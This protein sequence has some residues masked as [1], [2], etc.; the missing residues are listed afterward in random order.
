VSEEVSVAG[1]VGADRG[2]VAAGRDVVARLLVT[3]DRNSFFSGG[4]QRLDEAYIDPWSVFERVRL[5]RFIGRE[6]LEREVDRFLAENERGY[7]ILE[8]KA[9]LGK[10]AFFAHLVRERGWIS[11]FVEL[12]P[13][14]AGVVPAR[15]NLA[16]QVI[17]GYELGEGGEEPVLPDETAS[18]PDFLQNLLRKAAEKRRDGEKIVL[19]VDGLDEAGARPG[20][21]VLGLPR[22]LPA[23]VFFLVSKRPVP[24]PLMVERPRRVVPL[25]A[26]S[27]ANLG[28]VRAY[29]ERATNWDGI[30]CALRERPTPEGS[31]DGAEELVEALLAKSGGVWVYLHYVLS[32]IEEAHRPEARNHPQVD[33]DALPEG[34]WAYYAD[35]WRRWKEEHGDQWPRVHRPLLATLAAA[36]EDV[37]LKHLCMLAGIDEV[38][39]L[40][41]RW[42]PFLAV[43]KGEEPAYRLYHGSLEDFLHGRV[44]P[45]ELAEDEEAFADEL[46]R[47]TREAH[48]RIAE[49]YLSAWGGLEIGL[50]GLG[51]EGAR[52]L[53]GRYG[54]RRVAF[55]LVRAGREDAL[56]RL[57]QLERQDGPAP[58]NIWFATREGIDEIAGY[59][60][61]VAMA[62]QAAEDASR[63]DLERG[64]Q[65]A[66]IGLE[67]RCALLT[68]SVGSLA[69]ALP[70]TLL[71]ALVEQGMWTVERAYGYTRQ[72]RD[73][74]HRALALGGLAPRLPQ[75]DR[76]K[77]FADALAATRAIGSE[78][79]PSDASSLAGWIAQTRGQALV[80]LAPHL[81]DDLIPEAVA[82]AQAIGEH[83]SGS[84]ALAALL[85]R[86]PDE[87]LAQALTTARAI[88]YEPPRAQ[89]LAELAPRLSDD[90]LTEA[91]AAARAIGYEKGRSRALA[92][93]ASRLPETG[94]D[95]VLA[96]AL[97]AARAAK[98]AEERSQA[99]AELIPLLPEV[100]RAE[101][102]AEAE[103]AIWWIRGAGSRSMA[104][105]ALAPQLPD[106]LLARALAAAR[107]TGD[108]AERS[109]ALTVLA[110][111][112]PD[113]EQA[114]VLT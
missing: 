35:F 37:S 55:H 22:V 109:R 8:A 3:G 30:A 5:D 54:L 17:C 42:R 72:I 113:S 41:E 63:R 102:L 43:E 4:Y 19:V 61:D 65:A 7:F 58:I 110:P 27:T 33:L 14:E 106:D 53:D 73:P 88:W 50:P 94:R 13:G 84:V 11:H 18:R 92:A 82:V 74:A 44:E 21:N 69:G 67:F 101:V 114:E 31:G 107:A 39:E 52:D 12:A 112:L 96:E 59:L 9:G 29:L 47:A 71:I 45:D 51:D 85:P 68:A 93:L 111:W 16:A 79:S 1:G 100:K 2:G 86:F 95:P 99:L 15:K 48:N 83:T 64:E 104:L 78:L 60:S 6:W 62:W 76:A 91:L 24:L 28:D 36:R 26:D 90:M 77:A 20:E 38:P 108:Q 75:R 10:S 98:N 80:A 23:G 34:L 103:G 81:P 66:S 40:P 87:L 56:H 49:R 105:A 57:L 70:P 32:E 89:A 97:A 46:A 25:D